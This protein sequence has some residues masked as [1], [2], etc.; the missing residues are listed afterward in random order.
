MP[1]D[2]SVRGTLAAL[3]Q[4]LARRQYPARSLF[5]HSDRGLQYAAREYVKS[6]RKRGAV[7]VTEF[8]TIGFC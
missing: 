5:H 6:I 3:H 4:A 2:R 7:V 8:T 1:A